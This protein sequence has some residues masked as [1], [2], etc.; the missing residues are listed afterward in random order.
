LIENPEQC[1]CPADSRLS[2]GNC[3]SLLDCKDGT[4]NGKCSIEQPFK[5]NN[6]RLIEKASDC[7]CP[8]EYHVAIDNCEKIQRCA[9]GTEFGA[10][11][12]EKPL[13]CNNGTL[14]EKASV[15]GCTELEE[16][17]ADACVPK[18]EG[19]V[20]HDF[21]FTLRG[22]DGK[23]KFAAYLPIKQKLALLPRY[24]VC[25]PDCPT[26]KEIYSKYF[27]QEDQK[28]PLSKLVEVIKSLTP[29]KEDQARIAI[30]LVQ[31]IPYDDNS[32]IAKSPLNRYPYEVLFDF[33]GLCAE[34]SRLLAFLLREL[35]F[36]VALIDFEAQNHEALGIK[37]PVQFSFNNSGYCFV[38]STVPSIISDANGNYP[39]GGKLTSTPEIIVLNDGA[40]LETVLDEFN[41]AQ[42][43][44]RIETIAEKNNSELDQNNFSLWKS[45]IKK[46]GIITE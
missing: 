7:G 34:K 33:T 26:K 43:W 38:E 5:C 42:L 39:E 18:K 40:S 17:D 2:D 20:E 31:H 4:K 29:N 19:S 13:F 16:P 1:G 10:C 36:G 35:G 9:D 37:C 45:L 44:R 32:F 12:A 15:C 24:Y 22:T 14:L 21:E 25:D 23:I 28:K 11:A 3:V 8:T 46:Y 27:D 30:S 6:G 41:D